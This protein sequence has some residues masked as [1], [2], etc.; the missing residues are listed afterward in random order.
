MR[1]AL[2]AVDRQAPNYRRASFP[3]I[4]CTLASSR[5]SSILRRSGCK[6]SIVILSL[7]YTS[8]VPMVASKPAALIAMRIIASSSPLDH[9]F[10][11]RVRVFVR[12]GAHQYLLWQGRPL[13]PVRL[14]K[15]ESSPS[16]EDAERADILLAFGEFIEELPA[17]LYDGEQSPLVLVHRLERYVHFHDLAANMEHDGRVDRVVPDIGEFTGPFQNPEQIGEGGGRLPP[18]LW[19]LGF[20]RRTELPSL[21]A[22]VLDRAPF[23]NDKLGVASDDQSEQVAEGPMQ[24]VPSDGEAAD[25][26]GVGVG[27]SCIFSRVGSVMYFGSVMLRRPAPP[28]SK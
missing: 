5:L 9:T 16:N 13:P 25:R 20:D 10:A 3:T 23:G 14:G 18:T 11:F 28:V 24:I 22:V 12:F 15:R 27:A 7:P 21:H 8:K 26:K 2:V 6:T 1:A 4:R 17:A 19:A